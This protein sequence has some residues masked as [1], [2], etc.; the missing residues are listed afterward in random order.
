M[1]GFPSSVVLLGRRLDLL[2]PAIHESEFVDL[3]RE[4]RHDGIMVDDLVLDA[5]LRLVD[6]MCEPMW[7]LLRRMTRYGTRRC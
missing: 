6:L 3:L 4:V 1:T 7:L 5:V 2:R